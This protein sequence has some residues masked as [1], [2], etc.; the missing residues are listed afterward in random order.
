MFFR[1]RELQLDG[2]PQ[3]KFFRLIVQ[4]SNF[5]RGGAFGGNAPNRAVQAAKFLGRHEFAECGASSLGN[6][7][8]HQ[9]AAEIVGASIQAGQGHFESKFY[10][11]DLHIV[12]GT[13]KQ[14][15][16]KS[17]NAQMLI[18]LRA[19]ASTA[20]LVEPGVRVN[21]TQGHE[22]GETSGALL[23]FA[24]QQEMAHPVRGFLDVAIHH[25]GGRRNSQFMRGGDDFDPARDRQ[26]VRTQLAANAIVEDFRGGARNAAQAFVFHHLEIIAK[27]HARFIHTVGDFHGRKGVDVHYGN[28]VLNSAQKIA[29]EKSVEIA[30][31][32]AL[33]TNFGG[34][35]LPSFAS[36]VD[37]VIERKGVGIGSACATSE[38]AETAAHKADVGEVDVA[39]HDVCDGVADRF[40]AERVRDGH[41]GVQGGALDGSERQRLRKVQFC[42]ATDRFQ[43]V[44]QF[45]TTHG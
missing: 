44:T 13:V 34:A 23:N 39:V 17:V 22:L 33:D 28:G 15:T 27:S 29:I 19:G 8:F 37:N 14:D 2:L 38:A 16:R 3:R 20:V 30:R 9:G 21:E 1:G 5:I 18:A 12:D 35:A 24:Q 40:A 41:K 42:A 7:L 31:Q 36:F 4:P 10:P 43:D 6:T 11:A 32:A 26:L 25:R 45:V